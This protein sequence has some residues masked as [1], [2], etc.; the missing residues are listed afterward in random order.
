MNKSI[1]SHHDALGNE[2]VLGN[3]YGW[4]TNRTGWTKVVTGKAV[5]FTPKG[6][7]LETLTAIEALYDNDPK[8][9][10][11]K[12]KVTCRGLNLFPIK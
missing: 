1:T 3:I 2:I 7:T 6:V 9:I 5:N 11:I 10:K 12:S 8:P 4:S